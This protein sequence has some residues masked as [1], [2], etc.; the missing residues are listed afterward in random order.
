MRIIK[1]A[2]LAIILSCLSLSAQAAFIAWDFASAGAHGGSITGSFDFNADTSSFANIS[3]MTSGGSL[4]TTTFI[5]SGSGSSGS[6]G[7]FETAGPDLTGDDILVIFLSGA[8]TNA[9]GT[10]ALNTVRIDTCVD[11]ACNLSLIGTVDFDPTGS[12]VSRA[13]SVP[14]PGTISLLVIGF[15]AVAWVRRRKLA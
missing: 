2:A 14:E 15:A 9:G 4:P 13:V 3:V 1:T 5:G 8:M 12:I 6:F 10:I 7:F 11:A